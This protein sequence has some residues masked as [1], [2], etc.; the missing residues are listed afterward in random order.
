MLKFDEVKI[1]EKVVYNFHTNEIICFEGNA[2]NTDV[3]KVELADILGDGNEQPG[4]SDGEEDTSG[5][6]KPTLAKHI[7]LEEKWQS[8]EKGSCKIFSW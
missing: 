2:C 3:M 4:N 1:K 8:N 5:R 6:D 7:P